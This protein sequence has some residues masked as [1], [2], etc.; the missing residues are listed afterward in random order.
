MMHRCEG[1][2]QLFC[3]YSILLGVAYDSAV[4]AWAMR[5]RCSIE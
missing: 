5:N 4:Q 2:M 1:N 3:S